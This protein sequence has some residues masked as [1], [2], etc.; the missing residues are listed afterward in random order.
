MTKFKPRI[1]DVTEDGK[2]WWQVTPD[3]VIT[4][5]KKR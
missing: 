2:V 5:R 1:C 3:K 4:V